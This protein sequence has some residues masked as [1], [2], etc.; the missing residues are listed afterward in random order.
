MFNFLLVDVGDL[1]QNPFFIDDQNISLHIFFIIQFDRPYFFFL[2][3]IH[4]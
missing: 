4:I 3:Y 1:N 2:K